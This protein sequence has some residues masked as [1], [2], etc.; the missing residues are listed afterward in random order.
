MLGVVLA[1]VMA[2]ILWQLIAGSLT[3]GMLVDSRVWTLEN[4]RELFGD[5]SN[6]HAAVN[7]VVFA[8]GSAL[9][10][11]LIG[12]TQAWLAERTNAPF[13]TLA[14]LGAVILIGTPYLVYVISWTLIL[15]RNGLV[16]SILGRLTGSDNPS[17][18]TVNSLLGMIFIEGLIWS[19][20][21]FLLIVSAFKRANPA[22]EEAAQMSGAGTFTVLRRITLPLAWP[23]ILAVGLLAFVRVMEAFE[24]PAVVGLPGGVEVVTTKVYQTIRRGITPDYGFANA[25]S[26][27][28]MLVVGVLLW[29]YNRLS[30]RAER[31]QVVSG[32]AYRPGVMDFGRWRYAYGAVSVVLFGILVALPIVVLAW[33]AF[34]P[35]FQGFNSS[36]FNFV[37]QNFRWALSTPSLVEGAMNTILLCAIASVAASL[38]T[39]LVAWLVVRR[40]PASALLDQLVSVPLIIPGIVVGIAIAQ[41]GL[42]S[43]IPVYGTIWILMFGY[44]VTF[45]PFTM[46][47]AYAGVIQIRADLEEAALVSGASRFRL[48]VRVVLPLLATSLLTGGIFA[49]M[50]GARALSMPIFLASPDSPVAAVS[51]YDAFV[52]GST[53]QVAAFGLL[54]MLVMVTMSGLIFAFA[55]RS[56]VSLY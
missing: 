14:Y 38:I 20:L 51:L 35:V 28:L 16:N 52:N 31:Y 25:L 1:A 40:A 13:R 7:T 27:T 24:V 37:L 46:R 44:F 29:R 45:L 26:V 34:V 19:P 47:F 33:A 56:N 41:V 49:F 55:K 12:G 39:C 23:A 36:M 42:A 17:I 5:S 9:L 30:K 18:I 43:P 15:G 8:I 54:W 3:E 4:F 22:L 48:F 50:Q 10:A 53:T 6:I 2:P 32:E 11:I 21:A